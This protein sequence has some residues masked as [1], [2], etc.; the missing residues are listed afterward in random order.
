MELLNIDHLN[1]ELVES[2]Q[3]VVSFADTSLDGVW[4]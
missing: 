4:R 3:G 2:T 1:Q